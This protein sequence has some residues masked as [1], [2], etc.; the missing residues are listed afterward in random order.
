MTTHNIS[1]MGIALALGFG[2]LAHAQATTSST[3]QWTQVSRWQEE[4]RITSGGSTIYKQE[5]FPHK[6][7]DVRPHQVTRTLFPDA[8]VGDGNNQ[9]TSNNLWAALAVSPL[10]IGNSTNLTRARDFMEDWDINFVAPGVNDKNY[11]FDWY[12]DNS[13]AFVARSAFPLTLVNGPNAGQSL[14]NNNRL[15]AMGDDNSLWL[16]LD[17]TLSY[18]NYPTATLEFDSLKTTFSAGPS[19]WAGAT[20]TSKLGNLIGYEEAKLYFLEGAN[21]V[22][23]YNFDLGFVRTD[24]FV[25]DGQL[26]GNSLADVID[27]KVANATYLGWDLGPVVAMVT[28]VPEPSTYAMMG[29]GL[30]GVMLVARRRARADLA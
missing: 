8:I 21:T 10:V 7:Y 9:A 6:G 14:L 2:V 15:L 26:A 28:A 23:V 1:R 22:H 25:F 24:Q 30:V 20:L 19:G 4:D 27:G 29:V 5:W 3:Y 16:D 13:T 11:F 12:T 18:Y 17:G